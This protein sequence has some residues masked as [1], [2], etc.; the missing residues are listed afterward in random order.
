MKREVNMNYMTTTIITSILTLALCVYIYRAKS[1]ATFL[2]ALVPVGFVFAA[3][4]FL[5]RNSIRVYWYFI[6]TSVIGFVLFSLDRSPI[7][8]IPLV[9]APIVSFAICI[10][11]ES[12]Y[13]MFAGLAICPLMFAATVVSIFWCLFVSFL[14]YE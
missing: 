7:H 11:I 1:L 5:S 4:D 2:V 12:R 14:Q 9:L 3:A 6:I 13:N 8:I 10:T